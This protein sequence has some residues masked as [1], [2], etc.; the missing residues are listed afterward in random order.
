MK[1]DHDGDLAD[2]QSR[3]QQQMHPLP[4]ADTNDI[5]VRCTVLGSFEQPNEM[6]DRHTAGI[7]QLFQRDFFCKILLDIPDGIGDHTGTRIL[8]LPVSYSGKQSEQFMPEAR[9]DMLI[10]ILR[11]GLM[12][13]EQNAVDDAIKTGQVE[14]RHTAA[15]EQFEI[16]RRCSADNV[17]PDKIDPARAII[18]MRL[19]TVE[20]HDRT[21]RSH[22]CMTA[23]FHVQLSRKNEK[24]MI[25]LPPFFHTP[26]VNHIGV[27]TLVIPDALA[28][29]QI[30][31]GKSGDGIHKDLRGWQHTGTN[32]VGMPVSYQHSNH[33]F[34]SIF[35]PFKHF[36]IL[37]LII[38]SII[39]IFNIFLHEIIATYTNFCKSNFLIA[40]GG[41]FGFQH[42]VSAVKLNMSKNIDLNKWRT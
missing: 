20:H 42:F 14:E 24:N 17:E 32:I 39:C 1:T 26:A 41:F 22:K 25:G 9:V 23:I 21:G 28:V 2:R 8:I 12:G 27:R 35:Y 29:I 38:F 19:P 4:Q 11:L 6:I 5:F 37:F 7:S 34:T 30:V 3:C 40:I 36:P 33:L 18:P 13:D 10:G 15:G 16:R 31:C